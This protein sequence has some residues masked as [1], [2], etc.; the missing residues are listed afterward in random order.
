MFWSQFRNDI[1]GIGLPISEMKFEFDVVDDNPQSEEKA[2][3]GNC[4]NC[5]AKLPPNRWRFCSDECAKEF[6]N[7]KSKETENNYKY[8]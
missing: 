5:G 8:L 2:E 6:Y 7:N 1:E 3:K 4:D